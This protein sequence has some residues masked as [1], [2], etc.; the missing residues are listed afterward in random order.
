[1]PK[2]DYRC[3]KCNSDF[4]IVCSINDSREDI[5][6]KKCG[7]PKPVRIFNVIVLKGKKAKGYEAEPAKPKTLTENSGHNHDENDHCS[8]ELDYQ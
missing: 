5:I 6:C 3:K 1:M 7:S 2:Y 8:P 4:F